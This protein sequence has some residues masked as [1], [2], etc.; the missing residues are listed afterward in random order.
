MYHQ[1]DMFSAPDNRQEQDNFVYGAS[2]L[3]PEPPRKDVEFANVQR[4]FE[5]SK[6]F[7]FSA[8]NRITSPRDV[9]Y[10]FKQ[11]ET[12]SVENAFAVLIKDHNPTVLHLAMGTFFQT[13]VP[14]EPIIA[15]DRKLHADEIYF[16]HN[17]PSG[18][19]VASMP[20]MKTYAKMK[21]IFGDRMQPGII[22][23]TRSGNFG[24]FTEMMAHG[25]MEMHSGDSPKYIIPTY[26]FS[27]QVFNADYRE[28]GEI[29]SSVDVAAFLSGMR[30]GERQKLSYLILSRSN[31]IEANIHTHY[32]RLK[33]NDYTPLARQIVEDVITYGG[34]SVITYGSCALKHSEV[35]HLQR[36][37]KD[38]Q[39][40]DMFLDHVNVVPRP[41]N[42]DLD[43]AA[44]K[45]YSY[46]SAADEGWLLREDLRFRAA[47]HGS[48]HDFKAFDFSHM[49]SGE[50]AQTYGWGGYVT[51][52]EGIGR[53]YAEGRVNMFK[54]GFGD[55]YVK[56]IRHRMAGGESFEDAKRFFVNHHRSLY[57]STEKDPGAYSDF[58]HD[59][60][61]L[62][63][64][65]EED[66]PGRHL[67]HVEIPTEK[68]GNYLRWEE[69]V[70]DSQIEKIRA[71]LKEN[72]RRNKLA[73][74]D[75][76]IS[77]TKEAP[78]A[79]EV[80]AW[81]R[82]G[83]NIYKTLTHLTGDARSASEALAEM[84]FVG[85][86]YPAQHR[87]GGRADNA[88]NYVIFKESDIQITDHIRF[89]FAENANDFA[90]MR[91]WAVREKGI[92]VPGLSN[93]DVVVT[94]V[95]PH[96]FQGQGPIA[97]ARRW[98]K[99]NL[100]GDYKAHDSIG[101][102]FPYAITQNAI[103]KYLSS[104]ATQKS[105]NTGI[106][107]AVL[108]QLPAVIG[109]SAEVEI[110]P[111]YLKGQ[112]GK[113]APENG[114]DDRRL[115]HRFY[116]AIKMDG[117]TYRVKTTIQEIAEPEKLNRPHSYEVTKIEMLDLKP[118][119]PL[120]P[121]QEVLPLR[122]T[123][124]IGLAKILENVEK[125][126]DGGKKVLSESLRYTMEVQEKKP[127]ITGEIIGQSH[128]ERAEEYADSWFSFPEKQDER[129]KIEMAVSEMS[130]Q[131]HTP[132]RMVNV[133][134]I[135]CPDAE[136][137]AKMRASSGWYSRSR[138]EVVL[139]KDNIRSAEDARKTM[140]HEVVGHRGLRA[141]VGNKAFKTLCESVYASMPAAD[142]PGYLRMYGSRAVAGEEY[143]ATLAE[144]GAKEPVSVWRKVTAAVKTALNAIGIKVDYSPKDVQALLQRSTRYLERSTANVL[145]QVPEQVGGVRLDKGVRRQLAKGRGVVVD[146]PD[147]TGAKRPVRLSWS[148]EGGLKKLPVA[149]G[150]RHRM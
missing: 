79:A 122:E 118:S 29:H 43:R 81:V 49:G 26:S 2:L 36:E 82:R 133:S 149:I 5:K 148:V 100:V 86:S 10:I 31:E 135:V 130:R 25:E 77:E 108:K 96:D 95:A 12:A 45:S 33:R 124:S 74:F 89:R 75:A 11:L 92:V 145:R 88:R 71:Y 126:Y 140:L 132:V 9:A 110:H 72:Y 60:E 106:H 129:E 55:S 91:D 15:A 65:K 121:I 3:D 28:T 73:D 117:Q 46:E 139:V 51:E 61:S 141:V 111:D 138:D 150:S 64:L 34:T 42:Q 47:F 4:V 102:V 27:R 30:L 16:V 147:K 142:Q 84:G 109:N 78:N 70:S 57:E 115:I 104:S 13:M 134:D 131:L 32:G 48:P 112:D 18:K 137:Q 7:Q 50:G 54:S 8:P 41:L 87:S 119:I 68:D 144:R 80:N 38:L 53:T 105:E 107:L 94:E 125:S 116:G 58:R 101:K 24:M 44:E 17:H 127:E 62:R 66:L 35:R 103:D 83:E 114:Y 63:N 146:L 1:L 23:N 99:E 20:D 123:C 143:M 22:I 120:E 93:K 76:G 97:Q 40:Q 6:M 98:A 128:Q 113:R 39:Q 37:L 52:V 85:I 59:Y 56:G 69:P 21:K 14:I 19:L 67:Y 136:L 90:A